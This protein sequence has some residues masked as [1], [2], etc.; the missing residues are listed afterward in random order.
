MVLIEILK[1][2][3]EQEAATTEKF[4]KIVP[5]EKF[6]WRPHPKSMTLRQLSTHIAE[7]PGWMYSGITTDFL[8]FAA[9]PNK[10]AMI[11]T[12]EELMDIFNKSV[13]AAREV[14]VI[15]NDSLLDK[16]WQMRNGEQIWMDLTKAEVVRHALSQIIHHRAQLGV[17]LRLLDIPIPGSFGPSA[18][19]MGK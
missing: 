7:I 2:E 14:L 12:N 6:D 4:M 13:A 17:F 3:F 18:D 19:E 11:E 5:A 8:D 16:R 15:E 9:T 10:P 1:N